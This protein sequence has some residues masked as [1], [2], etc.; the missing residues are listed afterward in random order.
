[1]E[2]QQNNEYQK[3]GDMEQSFNAG[4]GLDQINHNLDAAA[5]KK[6]LPEP[7]V[8]EKE[9]ED[10]GVVNPEIPSEGNPTPEEK[11]IIF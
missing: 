10:G 5:Q 2:M 6:E 4:G 7:G 11:P 3:L 1:M 9:E 8:G